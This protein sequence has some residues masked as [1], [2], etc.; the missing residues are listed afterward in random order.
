MWNISLPKIED[1]WCRNG[2]T[3]HGMGGQL[4]LLFHSVLSA[5]KNTIMHINKRSNQQNDTLIQS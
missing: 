4:I 5:A 3:D 1:M 2:F